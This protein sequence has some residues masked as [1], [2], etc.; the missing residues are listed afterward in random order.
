MTQKPRTHFARQRCSSTELDKQVT[1][2]S[3]DVANRMVRVLPNGALVEVPK[4]GHR[5]SLDN[6]DGSEKAACEFLS[7]QGQ[8][9][10]GVVSVPAKSAPSGR[11]RSSRWKLAGAG[12]SGARAAP[13]S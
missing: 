9:F 1:S 3:R 10:S 5:V 4:A 7:K 6:A 8:E 13:R 11:S 12:L 2:L